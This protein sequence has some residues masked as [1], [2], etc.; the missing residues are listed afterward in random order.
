[1]KI[2]VVTMQFGNFWSGLG[3][4][5]TNL[6]NGL[7]ASGHHVSVICPA[8]AA[9]KAHPAVRFIDSSSITVAPT[10][11]NWLQVSWQCNKVVQQLLAAETFDVVHFADARESFFCRSRKALV[12][13]MMNDYYFVEADTNPLYYRR[14]YSDWLVRWLFYNLSRLLERWA[15]RSLPL[16]LANT[17]YVTRSLIRNYGIAPE[18][19]HT[20]YYG[21]NLPARTGDPTGARLEGSPSILFVGSNFQRKGLPVLIKAME[22][23]VARFPQALLHVIGKD[24]KQAAVEQSALRAGIGANVR[25]YGGLPN[26]KVQALYA[27]ADMFAMP[28]LVEGFGLV[29]LEAMVAGTPVIGGLCGGTPELIKDGDN[30]FV[31]PPDQPELLARRIVE[32]AEN[33]GLRAQLVRAGRATYAEYTIDR[34]VAGTVALYQRFTKSA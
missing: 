23:V 7:A 14:H 8:P 27:Q 15:I 17:D 31:V 4:Y 19:A 26:D 34:M 13:G 12:T 28:S 18:R 21:L 5:A 20:V 6:I 9:D 2:C 32:L 24:A 10:M 3:T 1:M 29:F 22:P 11:S 30:G 33:S 25:F 16:V